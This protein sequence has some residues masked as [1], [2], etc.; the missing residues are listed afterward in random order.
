MNVSHIAKRVSGEAF[1]SQI[2]GRKL[3]KRGP[4]VPALGLGGQAT[5]EKGT[6]A[7]AEALW[8]HVVNAGIR[9]IDTAH[10]YGASQERLGKLMAQTDEDFF[11]ATKS[12]QRDRDNFMREVDENIRLL[13]R[14]PDVIQVHAI[15]RGEHQEILRQGGALEAALE[16]RARGLC[17]FVGIT[18]H[19][20]PDTLWEIVRWGTGIDFVL[21]VVSAADTRSL[22][23]LI[24]LCRQKGI[25]VIAMKVMGK[26]MLVRPNGPGVKSGGEA[27]HFTLSCPVSVGI[28]GFS[29]PEEIA[30]CA[31][32]A[33]DFIPMNQGRMQEL[34][35]GVASYEDQMWFYRE[36]IKNWK[37]TQD[38]RKSP[39]D[40][41]DWP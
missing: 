11:V 13:Q 25:A 32:V 2:D 30:E 41:E 19:D 26:G 36:E 4:V 15:K 18:G 23:R 8:Q 17:R 37:K 12:K 40:Y 14:T 3:G 20:D 9:Y 31:G 5:F 10:D 1:E 21:T 7:E 38:I 35:D 24:P 27:L 28:V 29:H 6:E 33:S 39:D 34:Q 16:T 22:A